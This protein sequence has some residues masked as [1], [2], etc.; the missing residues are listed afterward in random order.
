VDHHAVVVVD[1][2]TAQRLLELV[3]R[4]QRVPALLGRRGRR[5]VG[6]E[7]DE[8]RTGDVTGEVVLPAE[9][10]T[11]P[12]PHVE[13]RGRRQAGDIRDEV[14]GRD[15]QGGVGASGGGGRSGGHDPRIGPTT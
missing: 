15:E 6:G 8:L 7:V 14:A 11:E 10:V 2:R 3:G 13:D 4:R 5:Q 12:P 1:A 9:R